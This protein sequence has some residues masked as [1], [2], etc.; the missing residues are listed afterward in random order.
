M[1]P[2]C[3]SRQQLRVGSSTECAIE[4]A[5]SR[6]VTGRSG[7]LYSTGEPSCLQP[8]VVAG[9]VV[10]ERPAA[11]V[12]RRHEHDAHSGRIWPGRHTHT[13]AKDSGVGQHLKWTYAVSE[14]F[15][16]TRVL[17]QLRGETALR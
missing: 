15:P 14:E 17:S 2:H 3:G 4:C 13:C 1:R 11:T 10:D 9:S 7:P 5:C 12:D 16:L 6:I 8:K